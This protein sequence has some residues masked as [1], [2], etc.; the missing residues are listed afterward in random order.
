MK[1][2]LILILAM[3]L[4]S[5]CG[6]AR[7]PPP[8][9][10]SQPGDASQPD[11]ASQA[12]GASQPSAGGADAAAAAVAAAAL[13]VK[14]WCTLM[15]LDLVAKVVP[16]GAAPQS[17]LFIP[18][19]CTVSNQVSVVEITFYSSAKTG[20]IPGT[21]S[22]PGVGQGAY[23][24][25]VNPVDDAYLTVYLSSDAYESGEVLYVEVAGHDGKSHKDDAIAIA[26]AIL[27]KLQ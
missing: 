21:E 25:T 23:L 15:P 18:L 12:A 13:K 16:N 5:A 9:G 24:S 4:L 8:A 27:A 10:A 19:T 7:T 2:V 17:Q 1:R 6:S 3:G 22:I 26:K 14:D 20:E 11:G